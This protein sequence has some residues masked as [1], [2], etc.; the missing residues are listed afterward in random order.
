M[1]GVLIQI[2]TD[3]KNNF[4]SYIRTYNITQLTIAMFQTHMT[5]ICNS[6]SVTGNFLITCPK[7]TCATYVK[8]SSKFWRFQTSI[9]N[10]ILTALR[11]YWFLRSLKSQYQLWNTI[12]Q[13]P[14]FRLKESV[15]FNYSPFNVKIKQNIYL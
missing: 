1:S 15:K 13:S 6:C 8:T 3:T 14:S 12:K 2:F 9:I 7:L 4:H 10:Y 5:V 11:R